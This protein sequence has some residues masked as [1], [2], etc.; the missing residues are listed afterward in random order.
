M[1]NIL[2]KLTEIS[3]P[4]PLNPLLVDINKF[5]K[6]KMEDRWKKVDLKY[7]LSN[8]HHSIYHRMFEY[9][10]FLEMKQLESYFE[11]HTF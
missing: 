3:D 1:K 5:A 7:S 2:N 8:D 11:H 4:L 10:A 6:K 9:I